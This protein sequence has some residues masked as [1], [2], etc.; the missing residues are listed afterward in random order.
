MRKIVFLFLM[1]TVLALGVSIRIL[2]FPEGNV[3]V[4]GKFVGESPVIV[5][6]EKGEHEIVIR[7]EGFLEERKIIEVTVPKTVSFK[8]VASPYLFKEAIPIAVTQYEM[9]ETPP[10]ETP[11]E[12]E[13]ENKL[14]EVLGKM[15]INVEKIELNENDVKNLVEE[16]NFDV[17]DK[18]MEKF[19]ESRYS[20]VGQFVHISKE[21]IIEGRVEIWIYD[22][23]KK[24]ILTSMSLEKRGK[25]L[26]NI[27]VNILKEISPRLTD[28]LVK[29]ELKHIKVLKKE[30]GDV[31]IK[32]ID[33]KDYPDIKIKFFVLNPKGEV[34]T[35][36][37][38]DNVVLLEDERKIDDLE[39]T[40]RYD[41]NTYVILA[42]D[43]S[44]SMKQ[45]MEIL[46]TSAIEF[47]ESMPEGLNYSL[48]VFGRKKEPVVDVYPSKAT[49]FISN[50]DVLKWIIRSLKSYGS[51]PLYDAIFTSLKLLEG[52]EGTKILV[53]FTDGKDS[54]YDETGPGSVRTL[55]D[56]LTTLKIVKPITYILGFGKKIDEKVLNKIAEESNG[57]FLKI[58]KAEEIK[59]VY[60]SIAKKLRNVYTLSY[61]TLGGKL[62]RVVIEDGYRAETEISL[63]RPPEKPK[64][65]SGTGEQLGDTVLLEW[66]CKDPDDDVLIYQILFGKDPGPLKKIAEVKGNKYEIRNLELDTT[67][68]WRVIAFD[69]TSFTASDLMKFTTKAKKMTKEEVLKELEIGNYELIMKKMERGETVLPEDE[70]LALYV[71]ALSKYVS[72]GGEVK[73]LDEIKKEIEDAMILFPK[74]PKLRGALAEVYLME[75]NIKKAKEELEMAIKMGLEKT[76]VDSIKIRIADI[77]GKQKEVVDVVEKMIRSG[78]PDSMMKAADILLERGEEERALE[79]VRKLRKMN[80]KNLIFLKKEVRILREIG[81]LDE[82]LE[83]IEE[84]LK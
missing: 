34:E 37:K 61:K 68:Y 24:E 39:L 6:V 67:Y 56:V 50:K 72:E 57:R 33:Y 46:K 22:L 29:E 84:G 23:K 11:E 66:E 83:V 69:G 28:L 13:F 51:T 41:K 81:K 4:D 10:R 2:S 27:I 19:P 36:L 71:R 26:D 78:E 20:I 21:N 64:I 30:E 53:V 12:R 42:I 38:K 8:L 49:P 43:T 76:W 47:L 82:A 40:G 45:Y 58:N 74:S 59:E 54:N 15:N 32:E 17:L 80:P 52:V 73:N 77:E 60:S 48:V 63:N 18:I 25:N 14:L 62:L 5:D 35:S 1:S 31:I 75:G 70:F 79:V 7:R 65:I 9:T 44:G 55:E 16:F 3:F